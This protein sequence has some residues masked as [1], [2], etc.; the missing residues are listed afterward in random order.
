MKP[1]VPCVFAQTIII[2]WYLRTRDTMG[3]T[4]LSLVYRWV[5]PISEVK[6]TI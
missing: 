6:N 1:I 2:Q 4:I 5:I 3:P